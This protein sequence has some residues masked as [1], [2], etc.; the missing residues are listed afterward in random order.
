MMSEHVKTYDLGWCLAKIVMNRDRKPER[1]IIVS[2]SDSSETLHQPAESICI[3]GT[4]N[5]ESLHKALSDCLQ[6]S[7]DGGE[8]L[9]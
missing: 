2:P 8:R 4:Y 9:R 7:R 3:Y 6:V 1:L 5:I